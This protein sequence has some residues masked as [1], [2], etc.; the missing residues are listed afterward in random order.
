[1][2]SLARLTLA[3]GARVSGSDVFNGNR[4]SSLASLGVKIHIGHSR[5]NVRNASLVV[6]SHAISDDN[7]ELSEA[8]RLSIPTVTRAEY[9]GALMLDYSSRIGISG[10][11]GK[12]TTTAMLDL[13][14]D[15]GG[16]NHT[17]LSGANLI[18]DEPLRIGMGGTLVY[19]ACEYKDSF[20]RFSPTIAAALNLEY[21]HADY[22]SNLDDLVNSF[23]TSLTRAKDLALVNG[24]DANLRE[25]AKSISTKAI[26][27]GS[28]DTN[29]YRYEITRFDDS[30]FDFSLSKFGSNIGNVRLNIPGVYNVTNATAA[31]TIALEYGIPMSTVSDALSSFKGVEGRLQYIGSRF[32]RPVYLDYA[33][34]PTEISSAISALKALVHRPLTVIFKPHTYSRTKALWQEFCS[35]LSLAD[36]LVIT[37]IFPARE[38]PIEGVTSHRLASEIDGAIYAKDSDVPYVTDCFTSG[39]IVLMG[40]GSFEQIKKEIVKTKEHL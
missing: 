27:F 33:H 35:A 6:C 26:T 4:I 22:F 14:F 23:R 13:I 37:D 31:A 18:D 9:L 17:T 5:A 25:I 7:P 11:H 12:S 30:G 19:E 24:D 39:A 34:H 10:S 36:H 38:Q 2:Y 16:V 32:G 20:L 1:M 40:A 21:D 28:G 29:D 15:K 3:R 8:K